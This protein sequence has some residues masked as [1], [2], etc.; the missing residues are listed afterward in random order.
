MVSDDEEELS[1]NDKCEEKHTRD[2]KIEHCRP[3]A[4]Y[5]QVYRFDDEPQGRKGRR[6]GR[7]EE[8]V[9]VWDPTPFIHCERATC[10]RGMGRKRLER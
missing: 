6:G 10:E 1:K 9:V 4:A 7:R 2:S 3:Q 5:V 8:C